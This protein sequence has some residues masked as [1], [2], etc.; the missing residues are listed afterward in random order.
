MSSKKKEVI[1]ISPHPHESWKKVADNLEE[2]TI[3]QLQQ[4]AEDVIKFDF[5]V[6]PS[7]VMAKV[8]VLAKLINERLRRLELQPPSDHLSKRR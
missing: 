5:P 7:Q 4:A 6:E 3:E 1:N 2:A 8:W